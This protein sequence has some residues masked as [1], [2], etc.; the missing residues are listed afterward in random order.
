MSPR[1]SSSS[2]SSARG[3][4]IP[5][6]ATLVAKLYILPA[7]L[8]GVTVQLIASLKQLKSTLIALGMAALV[9]LVLVRLVPVLA[10]GDVAIV[11]FLTILITWFTRNKS[12]TDK[13][14]GGDGTDTVGI[15]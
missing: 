3:S 4:L 6:S 7:I 1:W 5:E 12:V 9:I 13:R 10:P 11:V 8:G 14:S 2:A 15:N